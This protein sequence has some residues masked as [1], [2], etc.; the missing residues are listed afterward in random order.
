ME[1]QYNYVNKLDVKYANLEKM[2]I[3]QMIADCKDKW[4]NEPPIYFL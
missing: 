4:Y 3:P 1:N 2:D